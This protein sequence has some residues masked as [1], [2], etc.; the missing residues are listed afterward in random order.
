MSLCSN[1]LEIGLAKNQKLSQKLEILNGVTNEC[2]LEAS[3]AKVTWRAAFKH[4]PQLPF[5]DTFG[6][7]T[8]FCNCIAAS[9][10]V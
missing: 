10:I 2:Q 4:N 5:S 6:L 8:T 7:N 3:H 9:C 1:V